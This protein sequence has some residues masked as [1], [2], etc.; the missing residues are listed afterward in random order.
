MLEYWFF[1]FRGFQFE[2]KIVD[3][4]FMREN[5]GQRKPVL[6]HILRSVSDVSLNNC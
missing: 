5:A 4:I 3:S 2:G 1:L 6:W